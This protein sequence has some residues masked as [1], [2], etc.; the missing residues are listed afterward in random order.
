MTERWIAPRPWPLH[1]SLVC[2][3]VLAV[4][5]V[6]SI[7]RVL[8]A[9]KTVWSW[10]AAECR[11]RGS[12]SDPPEPSSGSPEQRNPAAPPFWTQF[13]FIFLL[14]LGFLLIYFFLAPPLFFW[15]SIIIFFKSSLGFRSAGA[16]AVQCWHFCLSLS[17][18][19]RK[20]IL[21]AVTQNPPPTPPLLFPPTSCSAPL[22][23]KWKR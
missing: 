6:G 3:Q 20:H 2:P 5:G 14:K 12:H 22:S 10:T 1:F 19:H 17:V 8:T 23:S 18:M 16:Q 7:V 9:R 15:V 13:P 4:G 11:W 21:G